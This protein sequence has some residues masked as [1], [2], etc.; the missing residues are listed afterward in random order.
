MVMGP[1]NFP[2]L[3]YARTDSLFSHLYLF[4]FLLSLLS[5]EI[6]PIPSPSI[7]TTHRTT[8]LQGYRTAVRRR[9]I[10]LLPPLEPSVVPLCKPLFYYLD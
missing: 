10:L 2:S 3:S 8:T 7:N 4:F 1:L 6:E 5:I 9:M